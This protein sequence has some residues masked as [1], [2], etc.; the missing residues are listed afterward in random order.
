MELDK[1]VNNVDGLKKPSSLMLHINYVFSS[2]E[3]TIFVQSI[4]NLP[5]SMV[6]H[7]YLSKQGRAP[8][9]SH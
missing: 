7:S 3:V 9:S 4:K 1:N 5:S 8:C 2:R 6:S